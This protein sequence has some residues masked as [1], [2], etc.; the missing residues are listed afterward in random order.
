MS[1]V[2]VVSEWMSRRLRPEPRC[3][4]EI[5]NC[6]LDLT[7]A[8]LHLSDVME[9]DC[10]KVVQ[11]ERRGLDDYPLAIP[12]SL[13]EMACKSGLGHR[14]ISLQSQSC[15]ARGIWHDCQS[16]L[17][18]LRS[19]FGV[20]C[21]DKTVLSF[22]RPS[23]SIRRSALRAK[24]VRAR[25]ND[26]SAPAQSPRMP[27]ASP[28]RRLS[29]AFCLIVSSGSCRIHSSTRLERDLTTR[30]PRRTWQLSRA[31]CRCRPALR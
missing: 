2:L 30:H 24:Y 18:S 31:A 25:S 4:V 13:R 5:R 29:R 12:D 14:N 1:E 11:A 21:V 22:R 27:N 23:A 28:Y 10:C 7:H 6:V 3:P 9:S 8:E 26:S 19:P 16:G 15:T 20:A 17:R